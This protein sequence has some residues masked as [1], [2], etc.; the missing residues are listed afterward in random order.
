MADASAEATGGDARVAAGD[1][2][3]TGTARRA[4][5]E[6]GRRVA[7]A[8]DR[9]ATGV[10][11]A[12]RADD[13][14]PRRSLRPLAICGEAAAFAL[15]AMIAA[16]RVE[17]GPDAWLLAVGWV[18]VAISAGAAIVFAARSGRLDGTAAPTGARSAA[19]AETIAVAEPIA[20]DLRLPSGAD[21]GEPGTASGRGGER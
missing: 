3:G 8:K 12:H 17:G 6:E 13:R 15:L 1:S 4:A 7:P 16:N 9:G 10:G 2:T 18:A 5:G 19:P 20:A 11:T 21:R 14:L